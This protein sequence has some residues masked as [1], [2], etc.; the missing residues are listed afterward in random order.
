[1]DEAPGACPPGGI[2]HRLG[3]G[4]IALRETGAIGRVHHARDMDHRIGAADQ[5]GQR[6]RRIKRA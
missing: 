3:P 4:D 2:D 6:D 1:M 5:V